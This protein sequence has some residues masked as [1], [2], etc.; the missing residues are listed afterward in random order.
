MANIPDAVFY[1]KRVP[2]IVV[3][4][5]GGHVHLC[6]DVGKNATFEVV[7]SRNVWLMARK[8]A[9]QVTDQL[10][11]RGSVVAFNGDHAEH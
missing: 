1:V 11:A 10:T 4:D 3:D 5:D 9:N 7:L 6:Y 8:C 2:S